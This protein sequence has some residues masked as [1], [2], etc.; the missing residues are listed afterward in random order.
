[1]TNETLFGL[2]L[3][4]IKRR[5]SSNDIPCDKNSPINPN[6]YLEP[7]IRGAEKIMRNRDT[8]DKIKNML[9]R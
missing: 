8:K 4:E 5:C 6:E 1:M 7:C 3:E 9:R 2:S